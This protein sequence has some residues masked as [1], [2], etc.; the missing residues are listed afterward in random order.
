MMHTLGMTLF[1]LACEG[2]R[3]WEARAASSEEPGTLMSRAGEF[4]SVQNRREHLQASLVRRERGREAP[5]ATAEWHTGIRT[6]RGCRGTGGHP[7]LHTRSLSCLGG[8]TRELL[9]DWGVRA[10]Q[11][12][13]NYEQW[14]WAV[15]WRTGE[16]WQQICYLGL[17]PAEEIIS[18][19][20]QQ[21]ITEWCTSNF[22]L[23]VIQKKPATNF[24]WLCISYQSN[25]GLL[26]QNPIT[27]TGKLL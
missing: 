13:T 1:W 10:W 6:L 20:K 14:R 16:G 15:K 2:R 11:T 19:R 24:S 18:S 4:L 3:E 12:Q 23:C 21:S 25:K 7:C 22:C 8:H 5:A 9:G 26:E 17:C 27:K